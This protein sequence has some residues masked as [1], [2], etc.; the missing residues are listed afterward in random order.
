MSAG[1]LM[2]IP[3]PSTSEYTRLFGPAMNKYKKLTGQDLD[4]HTHSS[5]I[6][7]FESKGTVLEVLRDQME[8]FDE[9]HEG[10]ERLMMWLESIIDILCMVS[11]KLGESTEVVSIRVQYSL[12]YYV[13][14]WLF[15]QLS[16]PARAIC[17]AIVVLLDVGNFPNVLCVTSYLAIASDG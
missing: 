2:N 16:P 9:V 17:T 4:T 5:N 1:D 7:K 10:N 15:P 12:P 3:G 11:A 14:Q 13:M 6:D 8:G